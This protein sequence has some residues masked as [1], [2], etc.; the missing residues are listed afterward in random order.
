MMASST[1]PTT[2]DYKPGGT[3]NILQGDVVGW[4][5]ESGQ[6]EMGQWVYIK[7]ATKND[8]IVTIITVY[9]PCKVSKRNGITSYHQ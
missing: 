3:M 6:D 7:L 5:V 2:N 1:I 8:K 9:Q 4:I